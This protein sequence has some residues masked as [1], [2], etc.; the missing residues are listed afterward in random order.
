MEDPR[1]HAAPSPS[2]WRDWASGAATVSML[3]FAGAMWLDARAAQHSDGGPDT[4]EVGRD[5]P[6]WQRYAAPADVYHAGGPDA[7][8]VVVFSDYQCAACRALHQ[9][10]RDLLRGAGD[11]LQVL[12]RHYPLRSAGTTSLDAARIAICA[13]TQG[14][15]PTVH[16]ALLASPLTDLPAQ[17]ARFA[18]LAGFSD[19][20]GLE[21]CMRSEAVAD[22][23]AADGAAKEALRIRGTPS[24][25]VNGRLY[26]GVMAPA[27]LARILAQARSPR[28]TAKT[29]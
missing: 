10:L 24:Y 2:R 15:F 8:Q 4:P 20:A 12:S 13:A 28:A 1:A 18:S 19:A 22:R 3:L 25:L 14:T 7:V 16:D 9:D 26:E 29:P 21:R 5:V 17:M 6:Q 27:E 23:L 11:S